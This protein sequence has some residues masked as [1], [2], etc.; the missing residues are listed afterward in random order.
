MEEEQ[1]EVEKLVTDYLE[2]SKKTR[3]LVNIMALLIS[4][5]GVFTLGYWMYG[6]TQNINTLRSVIFGLLSSIGM[7]VVAVL[8]WRNEK[9]SE[10][11]TR[12]ILERYKK[13]KTN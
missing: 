4:C 10:E 8:M 2:Q 13:E 11:G 1:D 5:L 9:R 7:I 12:A 6:L 3:K